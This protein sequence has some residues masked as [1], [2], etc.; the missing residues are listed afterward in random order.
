[1]FGL[2]NAFKK[3]TDLLPLPDKDKDKD[4]GGRKDVN[5]QAKDLKGDKGGDKDDKKNKDK[6]DETKKD[7]SKKPSSS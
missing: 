7:H 3:V 6:K 1:M 2:E 5:H 4:G